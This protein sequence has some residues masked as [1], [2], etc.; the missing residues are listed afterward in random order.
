MAMQKAP[1]ATPAEEAQW[2]VIHAYSGQEEK[3]KKNL[4]KR[5]ESMDMQDKI[6]QV[7]VPMEDETEIKD[8]TRRHVQK[9]IFPRYSLVKMK[10]SDQSWF[11]LRNAHGGTILVGSAK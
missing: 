1:L 8:G 10:L 6:L 4:E 11:V 5:I 7:L 2:Y 3:V 9:R